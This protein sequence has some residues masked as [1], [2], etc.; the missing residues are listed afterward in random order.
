MIFGENLKYS[1]QTRLFWF[2]SLKLFLMSIPGEN[3]TLPTLNWG[4]NLKLESEIL[5]ATSSLASSFFGGILKGWW[6][7]LRAPTLTCCPGSKEPMRRKELQQSSGLSYGEVQASSSFQHCMTIVRVM[8]GSIIDQDLPQT[9]HI[10]SCR[11]HCTLP[12]YHCHQIDPIMQ[13]GWILCRDSRNQSLHVKFPLQCKAKL[14]P[15]KD[16]QPTRQL[17]RLWQKIYTI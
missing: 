14:S 16:R 6:W 12:S 9:I 8:Q 3:S 17:I 1:K 2:C 10:G 13:A 7:Q 4:G 15:R 5:V 11:A